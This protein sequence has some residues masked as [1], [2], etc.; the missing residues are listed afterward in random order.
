MSSV[1]GS[2]GGHPSNS[3]SMSRIRSL[4]EREQGCGPGLATGMIL[5]FITD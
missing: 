1:G 3:E 2:S 4:M 5:G